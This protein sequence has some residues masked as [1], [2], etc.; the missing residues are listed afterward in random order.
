MGSIESSNPVKSILSIVRLFFPGILKSIPGKGIRRKLLEL[1]KR[2]LRAHST[3]EKLAGSLALG[4]FMGIFPVHGFQVVVLL[5][6]TFFFRLNRPLAMIGVNVS[7]AP[8][9]PFWIA[10]G[11]AVGNLMLPAEFVKSIA[12]GLE[13]NLPVQLVEWIRKVPVPGMIEGAVSWF[14]GS[15]VLATVFG[16]GTFFAAY[17]VIRSLQRKSLSSKN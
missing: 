11:V 15:M 14:F 9:L 13:L 12:A 7:F 8:F 6:M 1:F 3:P 4:V 5:L 17:P 10:A 2:E 16:A